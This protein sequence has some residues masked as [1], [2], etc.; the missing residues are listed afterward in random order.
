MAKYIERTDINATAVTTSQTEMCTNYENMLN[1]VTNMLNKEGPIIST[2]IKFKIG[3]DSNS[4]AIVFDTSS[5]NP[6]KNLIASL[7]MTKSNAGTANKF[8]LV[9][10]YD[11]FNMGQETA[12]VIEQLDEYIAQ[13]M[14]YDFNTDLKKM[15][16]HLQF[17]YNSVSDS[18]LVSPDYTFYLTNA[19]TEIKFESGISTYT[20]EGV[21]T[22][23]ADSDNTTKFGAVTNW[24]LMDIIEWTLYYWYGDSSKKPAHT[25]DAPPKENDYKYYIDIP[26]YLYQD[27]PL[28]ISVEE[29]SGMTPLEYC[30]QL[31]DEYP[32]TE[33]EKSSGMYDNM[34]KLNYAQRPRYYIYIDDA[35]QTIRVTHVVPKAITNSS[36][37]VT[38]YTNTDSNGNTEESKLR[39]NYTFYWG[40]QKQNIVIG[41]KP[42]VNTMLYLIRR[43]RTTRYTDDLQKAKASGDEEA[44]KGAQER[45]VSIKDD[46]NEMFDAQLQI[47]GIPADPP[48][49]ALIPIIPTILETPSRTAGLYMIIGCTDEISST[50]I[51]ITTLKLLRIRGIDDP[52]KELS[53]PTE[54]EAQQPN[55]T[56]NTDNTT[57]TTNISSGSAGG[58]NGRRRWWC[59]VIYKGENIWK[60]QI[61]NH[62]IMLYIWLLLLMMIQIATLVVMVEF[63]YIFHIY[64]LT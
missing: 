34:D 61:K 3:T 22:L 20:F 36:G 56:S 17:G 6:K 44:I 4:N 40:Q 2:W 19:N 26:D 11:P 13:S 41:W 27:S 37:E 50:G 35:Q 58:G 33:S 48:V 7:S 57:D 32:L 8:S 49:G 23:S 43:A 63:K 14:S 30:Q 10:Q 5:T 31:L 29:T 55:D 62:I 51:Y 15:R 12:D 18:A 54:S 21:S 64:I 24:K 53:P 16:G 42:E 59:L 39:I 60:L 46:L 9:I 52:A 47:I 1:N 45:L 28:N 38:G 25:G